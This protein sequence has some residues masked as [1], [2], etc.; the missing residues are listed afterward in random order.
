MNRPLDLCIFMMFIVLDYS[1]EGASY[2]NLREKVHYIEL[3]TG[4]RAKL[5]IVNITFEDEIQEF[6]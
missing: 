5:N 3:D 2:T 6:K 4:G 1:Q